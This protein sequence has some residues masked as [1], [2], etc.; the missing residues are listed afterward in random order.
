MSLGTKTRIIKIF[1]T[2][3]SKLAREVKV[4][5]LISNQID[6]LASD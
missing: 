2:K 4:R 5:I 1:G 3:L 6:A